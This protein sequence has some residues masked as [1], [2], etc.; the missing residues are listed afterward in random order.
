MKAQ[1][2]QRAKV[3][4]EIKRLKQSVKGLQTRAA[5]VEEIDAQRDMAE[6]TFVSTEGRRAARAKAEADERRAGKKKAADAGA[7]AVVSMLE[8]RGAALAE[9][10]AAEW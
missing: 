4:G 6:A 2:R 9:K 8:R 5:Y 1:A 3:T 10:D 7:G